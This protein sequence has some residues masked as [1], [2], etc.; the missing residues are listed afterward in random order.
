ML[1]FKGE[2]KHGFSQAAIQP[3]VATGEHSPY[4]D[5]RAGR[6]IK[7]LGSAQS[8]R[9]PADSPNAHAVEASISHAHQGT[10]YSNFT[11]YGYADQEAASEEE[12]YLGGAHSDRGA[13]SSTAA[14]DGC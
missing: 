13:N 14:G 4:R 11:A 1:A 8:E 5:Y 7:H 9:P 6:R 2:R 10:A 12:T 3:N